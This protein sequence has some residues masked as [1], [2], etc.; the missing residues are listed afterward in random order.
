MR[1][2]PRYLLIGN[3]RV[4]RH[5]QHY[6]SLLGLSFTAWHRSQPDTA[7]TQQL[8][9]ATH[10]LIL[11]SDQQIETFIEQRLNHNQAMLIHFSG[12]LI[13]QTAYGAHP[14]M[15][16][17]QALYS[18]EHYQKIPFVIDHDAPAFDRLLPGLPNVHVRLEKSLKEKYHALCVL[19]GNFSCLLWQKLLV[20][21]EEEFHFPREMAHL[22]LQQ[23]TNNV[24]SNPK[25]ALTGP[26]VRNDVTTIQKNL[27]AL[28]GDPFEKVYE[29]FVACYQQLTHHFK[30]EEIKHESV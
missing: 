9:D 26:L 13:S 6:F 8:H 30:N 23:Q 4:A 2:V 1:Q 14:L 28:K 3:G 18:L 22:Y 21:F 11:I 12:S 10:V 16:F 7:L 27:A 5:F 15:T 20:S 17:S 24:I 25:T 29:S 19:S